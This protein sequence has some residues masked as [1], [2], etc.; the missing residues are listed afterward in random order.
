[1]KKGYDEQKSG[2]GV[3]TEI[4]VIYKDT[5]E[6]ILECYYCHSIANFFEKF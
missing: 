4:K 1:M 6:L 2:G 3:S 5:F